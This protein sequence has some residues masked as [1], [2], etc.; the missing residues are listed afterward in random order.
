MSEITEELSHQHD[1]GFVNGSNEVQLNSMY[2]NG[3]IL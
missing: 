1:V 2:L 3:I